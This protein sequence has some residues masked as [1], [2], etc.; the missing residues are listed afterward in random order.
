MQIQ[1]NFCKFNTSLSW[2]YFNSEQ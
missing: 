1:D 2:I